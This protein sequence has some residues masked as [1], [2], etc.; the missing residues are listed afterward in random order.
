MSL[1]W[2]SW[3]GDVDG[4]ISVPGQ[5]SS[6]PGS[7]QVGEH[8]GVERQLKVQPQVGETSGCPQRSWCCGTQRQWDGAALGTGSL[9]PWDG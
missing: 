1:G 2:E 4:D 3:A 7:Q 9:L 8:Q 5:G 6:A